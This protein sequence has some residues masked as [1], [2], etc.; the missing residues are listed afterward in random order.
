MINGKQRRKAAEEIIPWYINESLNDEETRLTEM[1]LTSDSDLRD[2]L[3]KWKKIGNMVKQ[4]PVYQPDAGIEKRLLNVI[5]KQTVN[6]IRHIHIYAIIITMLILVVSWFVIKPGIVVEWKVNNDK[7][8][9]FRIYRAEE[10]SGNYQIVYETSAASSNKE[11]QFIDAVLLPWHSYSYFVEGSDDLETIALSQTLT[12]H[13]I[14]V[15]P[16]WI[17]IIL[18]SACIG[19]LSVW[20]FQSIRYTP[21]WGSHAR[22]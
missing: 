16:T 6:P 17:V 15:L 11:Y 19:Y 4:Q 7:F 14:N 3:I 5:T 12:G 9:T 1:Q 22:G 8:N 20:L 21:I 18:L 2:A 10:N 13:A